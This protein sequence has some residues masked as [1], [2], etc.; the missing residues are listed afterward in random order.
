MSVHCI[1][2]IEAVTGKNISAYSAMYSALYSA[3]LL[4]TKQQSRSFS[5]YLGPE[6]AADLDVT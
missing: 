3:I 4:G 5:V 2:L 6:L 1:G